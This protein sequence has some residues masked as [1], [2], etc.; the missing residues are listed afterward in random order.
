MLPTCVVVLQQWGVEFVTGFGDGLWHSEVVGDDP[1]QLPFVPKK[2][3]PPQAT[4][5]R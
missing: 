1:P 3:G 4:D 5:S 2:A